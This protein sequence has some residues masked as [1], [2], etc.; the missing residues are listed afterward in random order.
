MSELITRS[1]RNAA[2]PHEPMR[3]PI[4]SGVI[5]ELQSLGT[6]G[7]AVGH[8]RFPSGSIS[9]TDDMTSGD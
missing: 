1:F 4:G 5:A 7:P 8:N 3:G 2:V 6:R 9:I